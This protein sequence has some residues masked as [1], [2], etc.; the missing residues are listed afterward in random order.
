VRKGA[1]CIVVVSRGRLDLPGGTCVDY[2]GPFDGSAW[3]LSFDERS[4]EI[5][6]AK[7]AF[8]LMLTCSIS[9]PA[10]GGEESHVFLFEQRDGKLVQLLTYQAE[11]GSLD[12]A[13]RVETLE[14][15][16][17]A[18][19]RSQRGGYYDVVLMTHVERQTAPLDDA[20]PRVIAREEVTR[21]LRWAGMGYLEASEVDKRSRLL[22]CC[23]GIGTVRSDLAV[24]RRV[25][26]LCPRASAEHSALEHRSY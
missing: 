24:A 26:G 23:S 7:R 17:L 25:T 8:T 4:Y 2:D 21:T 13:S 16:E 6:P 14:H 18:F 19:G 10:S 9:E 1:P 3:E 22:Q 11:A 5:G 15:T 20:P 12:R